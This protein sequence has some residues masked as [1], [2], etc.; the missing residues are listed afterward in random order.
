MAG[1]CSAYACLVLIDPESETPEEGLEQCS[2]NVS[3]LSHGSKSRA[4]GFLSSQ[5]YVCEKGLVK[6]SMRMGRSPVHHNERLKTSC[7]K[8]LVVRIVWMDCV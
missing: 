8:R 7:V 2:V 1:K 3:Q 4:W 6:F 5:K